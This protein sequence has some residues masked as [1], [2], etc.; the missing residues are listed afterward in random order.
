LITVFPNPAEDNLNVNTTRLAGQDY[1]IEL[2]NSLGEMVYSAPA[3]ADGITTI[4]TTLLSTGLYV[5]NVRNA[6]TMWTQK[7]MVK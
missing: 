5:M 3:D 1:T 6:D 2:F 7:V 4:N